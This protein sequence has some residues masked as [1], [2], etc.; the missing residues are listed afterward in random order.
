[1]EVIGH[2]GALMEAP[3]NTLKAFRKAIKAGVDG[4]EID[5]RQ[6]KDGEIVVFHDDLLDRTTNMTGAIVAFDYKDL[7]KADAGQG[8][9]IPTLRETIELIKEHNIH[10]YIEAKSLGLEKA[11]VSLIEEQDALDDV[12]VIG[13]NHYQLN[14]IKNINSM[15]KTGANMVCAPIDPIRMIQDAKADFM[16]TSTLF[17]EERTIQKCKNANIPLIAWTVNTWEDKNTIRQ[18]GVTKIMTDCPTEM[19][20][21]L[22]G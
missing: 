17:L 3:E 18:L 19:C 4:I 12:S 2:R 9:K 15:I 6:S 11:L 20:R 1:M 8:E 14:E 10:L 22:K 7:E 21:K 16:T 5:I 13:F